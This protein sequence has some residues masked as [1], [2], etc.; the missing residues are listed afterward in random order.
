MTSTAASI[1]ARNRSK[2]I[3]WSRIVTLA[4]D[5][6]RYGSFSRFQMS[7]SASVI[8]RSKRMVRSRVAMSVTL[9]A[10][11]S[12]LQR[13]VLE[14]VQLRPAGEHGDDALDRLLRIGGVT[15]TVHQPDE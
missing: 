15:G 1:R 13:R 9:R 11:G 5:E 7:A 6:L 2:S 4:N 3:G 10:R 14:L 8:R 12:A